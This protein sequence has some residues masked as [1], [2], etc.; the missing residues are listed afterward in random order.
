MDV[1]WHIV[2]RGDG[3]SVAI[4]HDFSRPLPFVGPDAVARLID[5]LF[6][7]PIAGRTLRTFKE[8]AEAAP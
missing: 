8:L 7:R 6:V 1:T 5:R 2:P 4:E 3:C